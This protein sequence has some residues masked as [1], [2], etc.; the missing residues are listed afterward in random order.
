[1]RRLLTLIVAAAIGGG[2]VFT[3]FQFHVVRTDQRVLF[4]RKPQPDWHDAYVDV[5]AWTVR[6]WGDHPTLS[7]NLL[8][9]GHGD[10]VRRSAT[11]DLFRGFFDNR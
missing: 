8:A 5:R 1:M 4:V 2:T 10:V 6:D 3:A 9:S 7:R 11:D